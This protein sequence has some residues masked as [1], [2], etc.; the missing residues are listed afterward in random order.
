M[1]DIQLQMENIELSREHLY[2]LQQKREELEAL[3]RKGRETIAQSSELLRRID[4][5]QKV[6]ML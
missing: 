2:A 1:D 5:L 3:I 4:D 6:P